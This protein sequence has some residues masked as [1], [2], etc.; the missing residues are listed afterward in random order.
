VGASGA[1]EEIRADLARR[2]Y[3]EGKDYLFAA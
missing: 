3:S 2:G 1:R